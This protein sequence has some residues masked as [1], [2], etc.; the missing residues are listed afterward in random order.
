M[1]GPSRTAW[2]WLSGALILA[3]PA[4]AWANRVETFLGWSADGGVYAFETENDETAQA[5]VVVCWSDPQ[6]T[7]GAWP[8]GLARP[9]AGEQCL[10]GVCDDD[11]ECADTDKRLATVQKFVQPPRSTPKGPHGARLSVR[12]ESGGQRVV[13]T[14]GGKQLVIATIE[15]DDSLIAGR[16]A[17][18]HTLRIYKSYWRRDG[19]AVATE[20][21][22]HG[23]RVF[24]TPLGGKPAP[25]AAA[26]SW[27]E[28][29]VGLRTL[30]DAHLVDAGSAGRAR[31]L[32]RKIP[33]THDKS[34]DPDDEKQGRIMTLE[35]KIVPGAGPQTVLASLGDGLAIFDAKGRIVASTTDPFGCTYDGSSQDLLQRVSLAQLVPD[36]EPEV[37]VQYASGGR[38]EWT[39][40]LQV[41]KRRGKTLVTI[42]AALLSETSDGDQSTG[43]LAIKG[44]KLEYKAPGRRLETF[45]W[46]ASKFRFSH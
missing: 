32:L 31:A 1:S 13:L 9:E 44:Y 33:G 37:V 5:D 34:C 18:T 29:F 8:A 42:F 35:A 23:S 28:D 45:T 26:G 7:S 40:G 27:G 10:G 15:P 4:T 6:V 22:G 3:L 25:A 43:S 21:R 20:V 12:K 11:G 16:G 38:G 36:A 46:N 14:T 41:L 19:K 2:L 24:V 39:G 17:A 30:A